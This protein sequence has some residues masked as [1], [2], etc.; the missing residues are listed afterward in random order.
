MRFKTKLL[1][2][3]AAVVFPLS[4]A[5]ADI[6]CVK[7]VRVD[8][9]FNNRPVTEYHVVSVSLSDTDG[10]PGGAKPARDRSGAVAQFSNKQEIQ[11]LALNVFLDN[12]DSLNAANVGPQG[13]AGPKGDSGSAGAQGPAGAP[14]ATGPAGA[15]GPQGPVGPV[16]AV[17]PRGFAGAQGP[18][19]LQGPAG[20]A[21][22]SGPAGPIGQQ[23]PAGPA[24]P[25]GPTGPQ[26]P[27]GASGLMSDQV[28]ALIN[29]RLASP[30]KYIEYS[31]D[32]VRFTAAGAAA[33][34][35][36]TVRLG[37]DGVWETRTVIKVASG[38]DSTP[39]LSASPVLCDT[40][41]IR[42]VNN[43]FSNSVC[44]ASYSGV[45]A[46]AW[47]VA[48]SPSHQYPF[49]RAMSS[50][51]SSSAAV[52]CGQ[53]VVDMPYTD[54]I[55]NQVASA[56]QC[57]WGSRFTSSG[58]VALTGVPGA[59][60]PGPGSSYQAD[61]ATMTKICNLYGFSGVAAYTANGYS[62]CGDNH[63]IRWS[64][65]LEQWEVVP[66]CSFNSHISTLSCYRVVF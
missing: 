40:G 20:P 10:C 4:G 48:P 56:G 59:P 46:L 23:G 34:A 54:R 18:V 55:N 44:G 11:N 60:A 17:G 7:T 25:A 13:P 58:N 3:I 28:L 50:N 22:P 32:P 19:G 45:Q 43:I 61:T 51:P 14:G 39:Y 8:R 63:H 27:A 36:G 37:G 52:Q 15:V 41:F 12:L 9:L 16:G 53:G 29:S 24:G 26:G 33:I 31:I 35:Y 6:L 2:Q 47:F 1:I 5:V 66:A 38:S 42:N 65:A 30:I 64:V 49:L 21:G 62:S 57:S